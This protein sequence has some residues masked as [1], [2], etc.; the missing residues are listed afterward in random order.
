MGRACGTNGEEVYIYNR[1]LLGKPEGR[2][3]LVRPRLRLV[4]NIKMDLR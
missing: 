3:P 2:R 4:K 1:I